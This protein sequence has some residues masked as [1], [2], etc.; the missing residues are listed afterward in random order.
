MITDMA[1]EVWGLYKE[2]KQEKG[3]GV[4][5]LYDDV[6][7][8]LEELLIVNPVD[9]IVIEALIDCYNKLMIESSLSEVRLQLT[10]SW[11][12]YAE[13]K[14]KLESFVSS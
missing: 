1:R 9:R 3:I 14:N 7:S 2:A 6:A 11:S 5:P 10:K 8:R 13:R 4:G 12:Y